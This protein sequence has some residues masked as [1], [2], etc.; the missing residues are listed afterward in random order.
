MQILQDYNMYK[1]KKKGK[2]GILQL[3]RK[4]DE[5]NPI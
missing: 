5:V 2:E 4:F 3:K 1:L